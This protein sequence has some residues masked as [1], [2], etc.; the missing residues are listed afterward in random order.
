MEVVSIFLNRILLAGKKK[1][2]A[3]L[4][5]SA[6][7]VPIIRVH[8]ELIE[9]EGE[10]KL[11]NDFLMG[12][13]KSIL[14]EDELTILGE[15]KEIT[16]SKDLAGELRFRINI[17]KQKSSYSISFY[18]VPNKIKTTKEINLPEIV[19]RI[20]DRKAGLLV[21]AGPYGSGKTATCSALVEEINNNKG[22]HIVT[23][24]E[25]IENIF[26]RK[27]SLIEQRQI[28]RDVKTAE[29][30]LNYCLNDDVDL[31]YVSEFK[32][33]FEL[34]FPLMAELS[35][36]NAF[37]ILELNAPSSVQVIEKLIN[38]LESKYNEEAAR[39]MLADI[40][41]AIVVQKSFFKKPSGRAMAYEVMINNSAIQSLIREGR[42][43]QLD[44]II[45]TSRKEGMISMSKSIDA[46][47]YSGEIRESEIY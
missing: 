19:S 38:A 42:Y 28:G 11:E 31:V 22:G 34:A 47:I 10:E 5:L 17:F 21:V 16:I 43:F 20:V 24:E 2:A 40:L 39:F 23:I 29:D 6:D 32:Q 36:G 27:K 46:L 8:N 18:Y 9:L 12:V 7:S 15:K 45:Q 44:N 1:R 3:S 37:V 33:H 13:I 25:P 35:S 4:H 14:F 41:T 30:A 26:V